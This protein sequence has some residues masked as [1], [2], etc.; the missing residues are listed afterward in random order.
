MTLMLSSVGCQEGV[1]PR[2]AVVEEVLLDWFAP[3]LTVKEHAREQQVQQRVED[4]QRDVDQL[5]TS[6]EGGIE[7]ASP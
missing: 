6:L 1:G 7:S 5:E 2:R 4:L 3:F